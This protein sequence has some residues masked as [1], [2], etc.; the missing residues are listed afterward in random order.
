MPSESRPA[1]QHPATRPDRAREIFQAAA[2]LAAEY[3]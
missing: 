1:D 2:D 3:L